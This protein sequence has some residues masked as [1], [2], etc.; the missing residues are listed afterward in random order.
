MKNIVVPGEL[1][2]ERPFRTRNTYVEDGKTYSM[3]L[4]LYDK[5]TA[6]VTPLEGTWIPHIDDTVVGVV[7]NVKNSVYEI[8]LDFHIRSIVIGGKYDR[9]EFKL[10]DVI[11]ATIK[12]IEEKKTIILQY[13][14][15]LNGGS[16][17]TVTPTKIPRVIGKN[18]TMIKQIIESTK[19][20]I[21]VGTNGHIW[22][23][24]GDD[25]LARAAILRIENEAHV[26][27][28]TER[29]KNMMEQKM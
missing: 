28:L 22:I 15:L 27:G 4:G 7:S 9:F 13:P 1:L 26:S 8:D 12:D 18:N 3:V 16:V 19:S 5:E 6:S 11:Q 2:E 25:A 21:V 23:N 14:R 29:I 17:I 10:G 24:G 20:R